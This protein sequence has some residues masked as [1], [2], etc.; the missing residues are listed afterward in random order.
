[1]LSNDL[2]KTTSHRTMTGDPA[3]SAQLEAAVSR[4]YASIQDGVESS[5]GNIIF[6]NLS[7]VCVKLMF[8]ESSHYKMG[9]H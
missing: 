7:S 1:M 4:R 9:G 8:L 6:V 5:L 2:I 3:N